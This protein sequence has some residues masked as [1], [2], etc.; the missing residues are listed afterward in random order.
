MIRGYADELTRFLKAVAYDWDTSE[1]FAVARETMK[2]IYAA[3]LSAESGKKVD[4]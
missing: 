1:D 4:L 3:Y 2:V